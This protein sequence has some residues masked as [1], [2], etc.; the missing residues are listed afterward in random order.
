[1]SGERGWEGS[2]SE[3]RSEKEIRRG[4]EGSAR[5]KKGTPIF[6]TIYVGRRNKIRKDSKK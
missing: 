5:T 2:G 4:G 3:E 1:V 6:I